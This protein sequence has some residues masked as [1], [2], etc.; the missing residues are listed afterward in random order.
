M[1]KEN[2]G[3]QKLTSTRKERIIVRCSKWLND[4]PLERVIENQ[5]GNTRY[6]V[7]TCF[8]RYVRFKNGQKKG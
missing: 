7:N 5:Y 8:P 2:K 6:H 4:K 1:I 3:D